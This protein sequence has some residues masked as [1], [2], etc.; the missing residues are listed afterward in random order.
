M[1]M[2]EGYGDGGNPVIG[3]FEFVLSLFGR[4]DKKDTSAKGKPIIDC[5]TAG[6]YEDYQRGGQCKPESDVIRIW[7]RRFE[8]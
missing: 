4:L 5:C 8:S 6:I 7:Q 2:V 1:D 3:R